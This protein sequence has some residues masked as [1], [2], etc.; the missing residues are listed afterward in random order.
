MVSSP[1]LHSWHIVLTGHTGW[2]AQVIRDLFQTAGSLYN[3]EHFVI[4]HEEHQDQIKTRTMCVA[5]KGEVHA[6]E[7]LAASSGDAIVLRPMPGINVHTLTTSNFDADA[8]AA[9]T[10]RLPV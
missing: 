8:A 2:G 1:R 4:P 7:P 9:S 3:H 10:L 5:L 6:Q